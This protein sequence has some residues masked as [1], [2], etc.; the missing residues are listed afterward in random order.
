LITTDDGL[1]EAAAEKKAADLLAK[2]QSGEDF[3]KLAKENSKDPGSAAQGGDL[4]WA[5]RGMFVAPFEEALFGMTVG[6]L[7]GPVKTQFGYHVLKL[8][9]IEPRPPPFVR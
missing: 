1:D 3:A 4:G 2:A 6:E 5:E 8:E 7:R 9:E